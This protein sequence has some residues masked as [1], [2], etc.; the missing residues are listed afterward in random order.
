MTQQA[1][2]VGKPLNRVDGRAKVTGTALYPADISLDGIAHAV[3]VNSTIAKGRI[4]RIDARRAEQL[5]GVLGVLTHHNAPKIE[6][7]PFQMW[8][9]NGLLPLQDE[10]ILYGDQPIALVVAETAE[11]ARYAVTLLDIEYEA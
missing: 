2:H 10:V 6:H 9:I 1:V 4:K 5:P 7:F 3:I 11:Q 8:Q